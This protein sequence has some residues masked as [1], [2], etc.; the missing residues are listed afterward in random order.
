MT[1]LQDTRK[2]RNPIKALLS[3][4]AVK[5]FHAASRALYLD[6]S[7]YGQVSQLL[8]LQR[9]LSVLHD[10]GGRVHITLWCELLSN[11][12]YGGISNILEEVDSSH[13]RRYIVDRSLGIIVQSVGQINGESEDREMVRCKY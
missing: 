13:R 11:R 7:D 8:G 12:C 5:L 2:T 1:K 6:S 9:L 10:G 4:R 3:Y